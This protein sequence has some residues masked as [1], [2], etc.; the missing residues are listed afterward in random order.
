MEMFPEAPDEAYVLPLGLS[1]TDQAVEGR[2]EMW[3]SIS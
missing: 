2:I 3:V 1:E